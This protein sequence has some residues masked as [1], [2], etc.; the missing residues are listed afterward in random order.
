MVT[1]PPPDS[2]WGVLE[3]VPPQAATADNDT[4][5]LASRADIRRDLRFMC[6]V[7]GGEGSSV[8]SFDYE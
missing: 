6:T 4:T 8:Q 1:G 5:A 7:H 2:A 3:S